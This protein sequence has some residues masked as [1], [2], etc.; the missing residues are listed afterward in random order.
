[1]AVMK[2]EVELEDERQQ[3]RKHRKEV[4]FL[5]ESL[6]GDEGLGQG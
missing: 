2:E 3:K 4:L 1:M 6:G 5:Q